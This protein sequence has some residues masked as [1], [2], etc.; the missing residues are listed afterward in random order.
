MIMNVTVKMVSQRRN[1]MVRRSVATSMIVEAIHV[2]RGSVLT[3]LETT[4]AIAQLALLRK[5]WKRRK[6]VCQCGAL[7]HH[8]R[9]PTEV[10]SLVVMVL[11]AIHPRLPTSVMMSIQLMGHLL[12]VRRNFQSLASSMVR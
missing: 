8:H 6:H 9:S 10:F 4:C 7:T 1:K 5:L 3:L 2:G 11:Y 12:T